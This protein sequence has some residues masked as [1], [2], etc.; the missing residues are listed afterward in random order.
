VE[1]ESKLIVNLTRGTVACEQV[2]I[3]DRP[4]RRMRGLL[5]REALPPGEGM[6]LQPAPSI[7]T[8]FMRFALDA[9]FVDGTLRV[10]KLVES[11]SPWRIASARHAWGVLELA[12]GEVQR[13]EIE[14]GDQLG[15]VEVNDRLGA[16][17][18]SWQLNGRN[19][20]VEHLDPGV[21]ENG[22]KDRTSEADSKSDGRTAV[23][24]RVLLVGADRRFRCVAAALLTRRGYEVT[25]GDRTTNLAELV[26]RDG[27]DVVVL[28]A[29]VSLTEAAHGAAQ[30]ESLDPPVGV[31]VVAEESERRLSAMPVLAKWESFEQL[32]GAI[33]QVRAVRIGGSRNGG[34]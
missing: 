12:T 5:G 33:E 4:G 19:H 11:L 16:F 1:A 22:S 7:H 30:V 18:A 26:R 8:A 25:L 31:V 23:P 21:A 24:A 10:V 34:N 32:Y 14:L 13:R 2:E 28:D 29:G 15:V 20:G 6:L 17:V 3:A 27:A 9:V